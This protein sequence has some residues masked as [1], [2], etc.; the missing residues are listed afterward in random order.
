MNDIVKTLHAPYRSFKLTGRNFDTVAD[1]AHVLSHLHFGGTDGSTVITDEVPANV[2]TAVADAQ[3]DTA[4]YKFLSVGSSLLLDGT[5]DYIWCPDNDKWAT[6]RTID[7]W[8]RF[9]ALPINTGYMFFYS[10]YATA[11]ERIG[12]NVYNSAGTYQYN[13]IARTGAVNVISVTKNSPGLVVNT[14]YHLA[15]V[16]SGDDWMIFQG[17]TQCGIT[18]TDTSPLPNIAAQIEIGRY[19]AASSYLNSWLA[20]YRISDIARWTTSFTPPN[21]AYPFKLPILHA[22]YRN[23]QIT[24]V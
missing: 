7:F 16:H 5:G 21:E 19:G 12:F 3:I 11:D 10:Q 9:N 13:F 15:L 14:W 6:W 2:W 22:P 20:E 4:Q 24:G 23:F 18:V 17:G 8:V 1:N